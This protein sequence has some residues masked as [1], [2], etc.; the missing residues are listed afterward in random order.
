[1]AADLQLK[2]NNPKEIAMY[3]LKLLLCRIALALLP[4]IVLPMAGMRLDAQN[5]PAAR[6]G[7]NAPQSRDQQ[8]V[9]RLA[10]Q[11][12]HELVM[13][14]NYSVFDWLE[15]DVKPDGTVFLRGEVVEPVTKKNAEHNV[16]RLESVSKIHNEI[17]VL[18]LGP[19]DNEIRMAAYRAIFNFDSPLF[20]YATQA[21][22][23]IHIIVRNGNVTLKGV[24]DS[25]ADAQLAYAAARQVG[26][27][28]SV[29]NELKVTS[30]KT[31]Q[32]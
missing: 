2:V 31:T 12:R 17:E 3:P 32:N 10:E 14:S 29:K 30:Q 24:V 20:K 11:V 18:P 5:A 25:A 9:A 23:P 22:P 26:G 21:V 6:P 4:G 15:A 7:L 13:L 8:R 16:K 1:L 28:F 19:T 27:A